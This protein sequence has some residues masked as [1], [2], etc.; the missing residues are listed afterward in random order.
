MLD[1]LKEKT[2]DRFNLPI[3]LLAAGLVLL[4]LSPLTHRTPFVMRP[5]TDGALTAGALGCLLA[6]LH[7]ISFRRVLKLM[8]PIFVLQ[9][10][11]CL[12]FG[13][14]PLAFFGSQLVAIAIFGAG[15]AWWRDAPESQ[16]PTNGA[17][18]MAR[19]TRNAVSA[20]AAT[21]SSSPTTRP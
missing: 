11:L 3:I 18:S 1:S 9:L 12:R 20:A 2:S 7:G 5:G 17:G 4:L 15:A 19:A 21:M 13:V 16:K 6:L 14:S 10:V 8:V